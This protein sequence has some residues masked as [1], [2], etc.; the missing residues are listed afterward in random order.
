M[1][2][3]PS[4]PPEPRSSSKSAAKILITI[5]VC[6]IVVSA[7]GIFLIIHYI[8]ASG[9]TRPFDNMFG[10]QHLKTTS[11]LV[12]L[13]KLRYGR[14]PQCHSVS[15]ASLET[16]TRSRLI[17]CVTTP[18]PMAVNTALRYREA[19]SANPCSTIRQSFGKALGIRRVF[20]RIHNDI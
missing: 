8:T 14:Y 10:D 12:E 16:G 18:P 13:H 20:A 2:Q 11:A 6:V 9:I 7:V 19:G 17:V 5:L 1:P 15:F 3:P 4:L